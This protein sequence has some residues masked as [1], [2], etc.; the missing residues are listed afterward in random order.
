MSAHDCPECGFRMSVKD[1]NH[2][3]GRT[4]RKLECACGQRFESEEV[5]ARRL[6]PIATNGISSQGP[7]R[8]AANPRPL[9]GADGG[10]RGG[11]LPSVSSQVVVC[12]PDPNPDSVV[13]PE[14]ARTRRKRRTNEYEPGFEPVWEATSK[15]GS[16]MDAFQEWIKQGRPGPEQVGQA[17]AQWLE[18]DDWQKGYIPHVRKW[19]KGRCFEQAPVN[20][21]RGSGVPQRVQDSRDSAFSWYQKGAAGG[22]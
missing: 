20:I 19:I 15:T 4:F 13:T 2:G 14:R 12:D 16:K 7:P 10:G 9:A 6:P 3:G 21:K 8:I 11:G 22:E 18:T 5:I 17:W 1:T